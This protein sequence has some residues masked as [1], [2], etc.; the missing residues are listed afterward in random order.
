MKVYR[1][2]RGFSQEQLAIK[3]GKTKQYISVIEKGSRTGTI[4]TLKKLSTVLNV[5]LDML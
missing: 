1:E 5:D 3:I 2:Y 4:D